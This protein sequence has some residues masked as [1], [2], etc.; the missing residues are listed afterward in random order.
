MELKKSGFTLLEILVSVGVL[1]IIGIFLSQVFVTTL[2]TNTRGENSRE[3]KQNGDYAINIMTR[4]IQN[5]TDVTSDCL[6]DGSTGSSLTITNPDSGVTTFECK[7]DSGVLRI[8]S[9]SATAEYLS[10]P[11]ITLPGTDCSSSAIFTCTLLPNNR[12]SVK[13]SFTLAQKGTKADQFSAKGEKFETTAD[14]RSK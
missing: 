5:A 11:S 12:K 10:S 6:P 4:M 9:T 13:I 8:S 2:V 1:G 3:I 14:L 7:S